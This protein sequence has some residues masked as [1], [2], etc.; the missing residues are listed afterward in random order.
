[1][2]PFM[3]IFIGYKSQ[4]DSYKNVADVDINLTP[5]L[6]SEK[7]VAALSCCGVLIQKGNIEK[8]H[9][10]FGKIQVLN[11][12]CNQSYSLNFTPI[13][14]S[15]CFFPRLPF[16]SFLKISGPEFVFSNKF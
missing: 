2:L 10:H 5:W 7:F 14:S 8:N 1:M 12:F 3:L 6:K 11:M 13:L 16:Y 15:K 9:N 4:F